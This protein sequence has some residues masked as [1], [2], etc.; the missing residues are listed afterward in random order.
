M[1]KFPIS[2]VFTSSQIQK[3]P[4]L[5]DFHLVLFVVIRVKW[6]PPVL[7][8]RKAET[9]ETSTMVF[10]KQKRMCGNQ[11]RD[12]HTFT[13]AAATPRRGSA[14]F[15]PSVLVTESHRRLVCHHKDEKH[16]ATKTRKDFLAFACI[17]GHMSPKLMELAHLCSCC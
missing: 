11:R 17:V 2:P 14:I 10:R 6:D 16:R 9:N 7:H 5:K 3:C 13:A 4:K 12:T 15:S 8:W 1:E